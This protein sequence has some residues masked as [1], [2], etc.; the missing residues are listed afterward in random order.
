MQIRNAV[1]IRTASLKDQAW[2]RRYI[3]RTRS[4]L[5]IHRSADYR[6]TF[7]LRCYKPFIFFVSSYTGRVI[8]NKVSGSGNGI[9][10][11]RCSFKREY[12]VVATSGKCKRMILN[13]DHGI[14]KL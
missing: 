10:A 13:V 11:C 14:M 8:L 4:E 3:S 1:L 2:Y 9:E 12:T 7:L 5:Q 6:K